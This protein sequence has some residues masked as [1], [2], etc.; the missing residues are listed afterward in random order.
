MRKEIKQY[1]PYKDQKWDKKLMQ[2]VKDETGFDPGE[3]EDGVDITDVNNFI[4]P[5][6]THIPKGKIVRAMGN[7]ADFL[8]QVETFILEDED[9]VEPTIEDVVIEKGTGWMDVEVKGKGREADKN[10]SKN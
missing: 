1:R 5:F 2:Q 8:V 9:E 10:V 6:L 7:N 3:Q 4:K